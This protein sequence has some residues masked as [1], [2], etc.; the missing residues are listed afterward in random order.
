MTDSSSITIT[1]LDPFS[2]EAASLLAASDALMRSLYAGIDEHLEGPASLAASPG[3][4]LGAWRGA[5]CLA[6]GAVKVLQQADGPRY[7]EIKRV[8]VLP[9]ARRMGLAQ[10][11]MQRLE[12]HLRDEGIEWARLETGIHQPEALALYAGLGY[13]RCASFGSYQANATGVLMQ[14]LLRPEPG[15]TA[16]RP[17]AG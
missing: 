3:I 5:E 8:F 11:L 1:V 4:F 7:G 9:Q 10:R 14:K 16:P 17:P 12:Q 13:Q 15:A 2:A 6:C